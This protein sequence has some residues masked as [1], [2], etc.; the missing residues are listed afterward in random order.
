MPSPQQKQLAEREY[1]QSRFAIA[2][3]VLGV[4]AILAGNAVQASGIA[5]DAE[6]A[7]ERLLDAS[8]SFSAILVGALINGAGFI[9]LSITLLFLFSAAQ[10]RSSAVRPSLKPLLVLGA[11]LL[12][13]SGAVT[14]VA[15]D[16][17]ATDFVG[18]SPTTGD[19]GEARADD[20]ITSSSLYTVAA[21]VGIAGLAA[22][23]FGVVYTALHGMRTGLLTRFWGTLGMAFGVAFL[24]SQFFGAVG[25]VGMALW[26][27]HAALQSRGLWPGG[28]LPAWETG[29]AV[30]WPTAGMEP[31]AAEPAEEPARP[32]DFEG[33]EAPTGSGA[34]ALSAQR[35]ARRDNKRKRKR[36]QRG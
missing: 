25:L 17:V 8:D 15:Y 33:A 3:S 28:R 26:M 6:T 32:E 30:P 13:V 16:A 1:A 36:K 14:A 10:H 19:A 11:V 31:A 21:Y 18:G 35:P 5:V 12:A 7:A 29:T 22:F 24:L 20:L 4:V 34:T 23:A 2:A 9:L 27:I